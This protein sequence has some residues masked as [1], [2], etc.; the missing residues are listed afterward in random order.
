MAGLAGLATVPARADEA[1]VM[2]LIFE[3]CLG[4]VRHGRTPFAGLATRPAPP[5]VIA[6]LPARM[7]DRD[8][9]VE[10]LSPRYVASW[11]AD[12]MAR[13]CMVRTV[14]E[15][16]QAGAPAK[17]GVRAAGFV[18][19][20]DARAKAAGLTQAETAERFSPIASNL[21]S[22]PGTGHESG[23][24]RPVSLSLLATTPPDADGIAD[25]GLFV[26]A[27]PPLPPR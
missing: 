7:P 5:A 13:H 27:G 22:E 6:E 20:V 16:A 4:Y 17:L 2:R 15:A 12:A 10:L 26:M 1:L 21:W 9:A 14:F 11:G 25:A 18:A 23:P 24:L 19:R 3:D 8:K